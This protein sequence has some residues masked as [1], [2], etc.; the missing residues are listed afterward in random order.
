VS[1]PTL[2]IVW[3]RRDLRLDA[4][5]AWAAATA[6]HHELVALY[7]LEQQLLDAAGAHR[8]D[9]LLANIAA[10]DAQLHELGGALTVRLGPAARAVAA[11]V[12][13]TGAAAVHLNDE[14]SPFGRRRDD[15]VEAALSIPVRRH[16]GTVVHAPGT[17]LTTGGT[18]SRV[19]SPFYR[20]WTR[21]PWQSW[22]APGEATHV[23]PGG[24]EL[25]RPGG[26]PR[27][28]PGEAA[29]WRRLRRWL[30][31]VDD[32]PTTRDQPAIDGTS[33]LSADLKF[34][35][36]AA[37]TVVDVVGAT[38]PGREAFVRQLAWR[39]WWAHTVVDRPDLRNRALQASYDAIEWRD[40][41]AAFAAWREG[42]TGYP[43]VDA[44]MRQLVATGWMHNRLRMVAASFLV[45]DLLI[46]WRR[47]ER[48]FFHHL[49]DADAAQNAGNWQ[50][51]A[52]TGPDAAPYFRVFNPTAQSRKF[53][54]DG[55]YI[56]RWV[57]ELAR[58]ADDAIH[59]PAAVG[60]LERAA[61]GVELG[62]D[63]PLPLVDHAAAR[64]RALAAYRRA[65]E[66]GQ[67]GG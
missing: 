42:R 61:A 39:D 22:P 8:R 67:S 5:P 28:E 14:T 48:F 38:S 24:I 2:G 35:T 47:G 32:Y 17:V 1:G 37:R 52:G 46:D 56:R 44:A 20:T 9:Q 13:E 53:D 65:A 4:N 36:I 27:Q 43:I 3:F 62:V 11:V 6:E 19:F 41:E 54:P 34:G 7:V 33:E 31:R 60:A 30:E 55:A 59:E 50:W 15:A 66:D 57:P 51:V 21:T 18:L 40:D 45:K 58:L 16:H 10:L 29:A 25:L 23:D 49:V 26:A 63:Y 64:D 12:A